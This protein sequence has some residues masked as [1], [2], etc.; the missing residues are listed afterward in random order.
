MTKELQTNVCAVVLFVTNFAMTKDNLQA[1]LAQCVF[2]L[3]LAL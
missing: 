2:S 1:A 3:Q